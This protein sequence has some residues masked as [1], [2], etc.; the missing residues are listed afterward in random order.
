MNIVSTNAVN[1]IPVN[2]NT[3]SV[4]FKAFSIQMVNLGNNLY[5]DRLFLDQALFYSTHCEPLV[6]MEMELSHFFTIYG[7]VGHK[8][9]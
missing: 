4:P 8:W 7:H 9:Y 5:V 1:E 3:I 6:G 2:T